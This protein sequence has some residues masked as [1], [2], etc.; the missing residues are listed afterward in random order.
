[1]KKD[2][3]QPTDL[4]RRTGR[5][6]NQPVDNSLAGRQEEF[7]TLRKTLDSRYDDLKG[8]RVDLI[9]GREALRRLREK[10]E[11]RRGLK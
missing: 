8:G 5:T 9:D 10:S 11:Q 3:K 7:A 2:V 6:P 1:M 4:A